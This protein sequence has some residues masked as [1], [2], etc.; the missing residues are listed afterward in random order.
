MA[1]VN[2]NVNVQVN[3]NGIVSVFVIE[4]AKRLIMCFS[5]R[6]AK[7]AAMSRESSWASVPD[8]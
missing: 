1:H 3:A 8:W 4:C 6:D 5:S 7:I 2:V